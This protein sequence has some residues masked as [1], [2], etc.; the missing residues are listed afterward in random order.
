MT[1]NTKKKSPYLPE[2][3]FKLYSAKNARGFYQENRKQFNIKVSEGNAV[4]LY[5]KVANIET[6]NWSQIGI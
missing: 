6:V 2:F 5:Y 1:I 4:R 3:G